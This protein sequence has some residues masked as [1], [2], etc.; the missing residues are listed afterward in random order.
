MSVRELVIVRAAITL[1]VLLLKR[2]T[3]AKRASMVIT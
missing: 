1:M 2:K 3:V